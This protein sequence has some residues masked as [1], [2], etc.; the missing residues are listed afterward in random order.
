MS[1][2]FGSSSFNHLVSTG[3]YNGVATTSLRFNSADDAYLTREFDAPTNNKKWTYST[4]IKRSK[5][6]AHQAIISSNVDGNNYFDFRF[7]TDDQLLVQNRISGSNLILANTT[8]KFRDT[9]AWYNIVLIYDSDNSTS[10]NRTLLYVNSVNHTLSGVAGDGNASYFNV[11]DINHNFGASRTLDTSGTVWSEFGGYVSEVNFCDGQAYA[12]TNFGQTKN[13]IWIPKD[14]SGLTFGNNG[15]R[16]RHNQVG[17]GTASSSTIGADVSG[18]G[19]HLT[20]VN[21]VASDCAMPDSPENNFATI[22]P[23]A[24]SKFSNQGTVSEGN[25][26]Y[27]GASN[28]RGYGFSSIGVSSGKWYWEVRVIATGRFMIGVGYES[29]LAFEGTFFG[30]NPSKA[31][32]I[33]DFNGNLYYDGTNTSYGSAL[34]VGDKVMVALDMDNYLCWFGKN[35]TWFD[36]AT[37]TEIANGTATNDSTTQMGTQQNLNNGDEIFPFITA[38]ENGQTGGGVFNFGQDSSFVG[39]ETAQGNT[40]ANGIGDF[41]YAPPSGFLALCSANLPEPT[42]G[43]NSATQ[44]DDHF[45][46]VLYTGD[47]ANGRTVTGV[48][49][50]PDWLWIKR[51]DGTNSHVLMDS[52]RGSGSNDSLRVLLS[53]VDDLEYDLN[54]H[55][56]SL[57]SDGFTL[58]DDT[59]NTVATN[60][61]TQTYVAWSWKLNGGV[62]ATNS[63]GSL[64]STTQANTKSGVSI[65]LYNGGG[66]AGDTIG[67]GLT[68]APEQVWF[69]RRDADGNWMNYVKDMGNDGYINLDRTNGKDT[70]GSP[71]N[72]TDPSSTVITLGSFASLNNNTNSYIAYAFHSVDGFSKHGV[73]NGN[74]ATDGTFVYLGFRPAWIMLKWISGTAG[75]TKNWI[76]YDN[77]R[78]TFNPNDDVIYSNEGAA[79]SDDSS[80][81]IDMLSNGFKLRNAE[82]P[83]NNAALYF[84]MAFAEAPFKYA[85]AK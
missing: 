39:T 48:G 21:V 61:D 76:M 18:N 60:N 53:N 55:V 66:S 45:N 4:W 70:G 5:L 58:D 54:D 40:D 65:I 27:N 26:S 10:A 42:I 64:T 75:G 49:F 44:S 46:T 14:T 82:G 24:V 13:G 57:D 29:V 8:S 3:F 81:D 37:A 1:G 43:P 80:F 47:G 71:V 30:N 72:S 20:S 36:S 69:K 35:G 34:S 38:Q 2:P 31:F 56:R 41:Y 12:P 63:N 17:V 59:D 22:N 15:F 83:V 6:G 7:N 74:D 68:S 62:T 73:Y 19:N 25:L 77:K 52:S 23:L 9:S 32:T 85:N 84:Y 28:D 16:I 78:E 50:Q 51:R 79:E 33:L 11:D 67:H